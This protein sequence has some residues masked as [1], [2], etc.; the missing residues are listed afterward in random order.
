MH[1]TPQ[2][3]VAHLR[4]L[5]LRLIYC[6]VVFLAFFCISYYFSQDIFQFL[7]QP[8]VDILSTHHEPR[9]LIYTSLTEA[10]T[11][12]LRVAAFSAFFI[13]F[14]FMAMQIWRFVVPALYVR[15]KKIVRLFFMATPLLFFLGAIFAYYIIFPNAYAF[16]LSFES[17]G[18]QGMLPIQLEPKVNEY[19]NFVMRLTLAF[20]IC[21]EMPV[22]LSLLALGGIINKAMLVKRWRIAVVLI[23]TLAAFVTPPDI[24]SMIGLAIPLLILYALSVVM[25]GCIER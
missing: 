8:L 15:E 22:V 3:L 2:P 11:T 19:L 7:V 10:F 18:A 5:R 21:F 12:Y 9:R 25:I 13:T 6:T 16:F 24:L 4:E 20:G 17:P 1:D 23:F 14:P